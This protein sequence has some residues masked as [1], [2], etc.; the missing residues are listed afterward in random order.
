MRRSRRP[1]PRCRRRLPI[2]LRPTRCVRSRWRRAPRPGFR[3]RTRWFHR[4][5]HCSHCPVPAHPAHLQT[6]VH[7]HL[8]Q[9]LPMLARSL[10]QA[11]RCRLSPHRCRN[12]VGLGR[13]C[14]VQARRL[15]W[16]WPGQLQPCRQAPAALPPPA[17][18]AH[19]PQIDITLDF[20][21]RG[22][23]LPFG[24][25]HPAH[26]R[27]PIEFASLTTYSPLVWHVKTDHRAVASH[28]PPEVYRKRTRPASAAGTTRAKASTI[29]P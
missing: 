23:A 14:N 10:L 6:P 13:P 25:E 28:G 22:Q 20:P 12:A 19:A 5:A 2:P 15:G 3:R 7:R 11:R 24:D 4:P 21:H 16:S 26:R 9:A 8:P 29:N 18:R 27:H 1:L 17:C